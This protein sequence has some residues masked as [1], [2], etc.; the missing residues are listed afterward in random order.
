MTGARATAILS[1]LLICTFASRHVPLESQPLSATGT[2]TPPAETTTLSCLPLAG[3]V[4]LYDASKAQLPL[5]SRS[6]VRNYLTARG[7]T[8]IE[9]TNPALVA[10]DLEG[11]HVLWFTD[12]TLPFSGVTYFTV[13]NWLEGGG[14]AIFEADNPISISQFG[15]MLE[16]M[17]QPGGLGFPTSATAG[18]TTNIF[19]HAMTVGVSTISLPHPDAGLASGPFTDLFHD[20]A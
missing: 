3:L 11:V 9:N 10:T 14:R 12:M 7:A 16:D 20:S 8:V 2:Q 4:V 18:N 1:F 19:P 15:G 6:T 5:S 17:L 13:F